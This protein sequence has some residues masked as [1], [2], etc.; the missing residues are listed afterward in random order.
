MDDEI[1]REP[2]KRLPVFEI[3]GRS[4]SYVWDNRSLLAVP[5]VVV[6]AI[7]F[8][9]ALAAPATGPKPGLSDLPVITAL[10]IASIICLMAFAVGVHRTVLL[11]DVRT[12][13]AF[14][15]WDAYFRRYARTWL[16]VF[17]MTLA[18][19]IAAVIAMTIALKTGAGKPAS[20]IAVAVIALAIPLAV[21]LPRLSLAF[22]AAAVGEPEPI[23]HS[24]RITKGSVLRLLAAFILAVLPFLF[25]GLLLALP[26]LF[27]TV[28]IKLV[29]NVAL[30]MKS[31]TYAFIAVN[32]ALKA[33][34]TAILTV[35]LSLSYDTLAERPETPE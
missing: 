9:F 5:L 10:S 29:P 13:F 14:L 17:L 24:W 7:Q 23:R 16:T 3:A 20:T 31:L 8:I 2:D 11:R 27:A 26:T 18:C 25:F 15:R 28:M 32:A 1:L 34:S 6:F 21:L 12:G 33:L 35:T 19:M 22:P 4:Y 30:A